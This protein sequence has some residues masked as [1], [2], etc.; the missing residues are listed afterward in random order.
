LNLI[1]SEYEMRM[2]MRIR[3]TTRADL[4]EKRKQEHIDR[5]YQIENER[6]TPVNGFCSFVAVRELPVSDKLADLVA[7]ALNRNHRRGDW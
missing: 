7:Q 2:V 3:V 6:P 4:Y 5:G 1:A